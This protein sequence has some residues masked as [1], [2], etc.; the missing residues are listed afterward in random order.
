VVNDVLQVDGWGRG[1][2]IGCGGKAGGWVGRQG[3]C[4]VYRGW[5]YI[6]RFTCF[7]TM[8]VWCLRWRKYVCGCRDLLGCEYASISALSPFTCFLTG[9]AHI[10]LKTSTTYIASYP[11]KY[12]QRTSTRLRSP[13]SLNSKSSRYIR[14]RQG[15]CV[16]RQ[17]ACVSNSLGTTYPHTVISTCSV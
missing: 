9:I 11:S 8:Y 7:A 3:R 12:V 13:Q 6:Y 15:K 5:R 16:D 17:P 1:W 4:N 10:Q 14:A 2:V